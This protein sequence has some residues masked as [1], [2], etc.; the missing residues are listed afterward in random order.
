MKQNF[1]VFL[2]FLSIKLY[3]Q[4]TLIY[5]ISAEIINEG[6][7]NEFQ[8]FKKNSPKL[9]WDFKFEKRSKSQIWAWGGT[10]YKIYF[11]NR[12][13]KRKYIKDSIWGVSSNDTI[14][15]NNRLVSKNTGFNPIIKLEFPYSYMIAYIP[16]YDEIEE[17]ENGALAIGSYFGGAVGAAI[18]GGAAGVPRKRVVVLDMRTGKLIR[19]N[20]YGIY[21]LFKNEP[22]LMEKYKKIR[23]LKDNETYIFQMIDKLNK[24]H[25]SL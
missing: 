9:D 11:P 19:L 17:Q 18:A 23:E 14:F 16:M 3:C 15:L 2:I 24:K 12:L 13:V 21:R 7:Y 8:D 4:D 10:E 6:I 22:E 5:I 1:I 25:N 20:D